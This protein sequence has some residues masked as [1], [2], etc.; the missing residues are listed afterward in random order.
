MHRLLPLLLLLGAAPAP[1]TRW[2]VIL[3]GNGDRIGHAEQT[4]IMTAQGR[5]TRA[6]QEIWLRQD[7]APLRK[8][9]ETSSTRYDPAGRLVSAEGESRS[10]NSAPVRFTLR[11]GPAGADIARTSAGHVE[12]R[13]IPLPA[14]IR[15]DSGTGLLPGWK[16]GVTPRLEFD[17]LNFD[18]GEIEHVVIDAVPGAPGQALRRRYEKGQLR[19][20]ARLTL[21]P[22]GGIDALVQPMFGTA[23]TIRPAPRDEALAPLIAYRPLSSAMVKAPFRIPAAAMQGH[24]RYRFGFR[25]GIA[26]DPPATP[27]QRVTRTGD[28]AT[29]DICLGCGSDLASDPATLADALRPTR[30]LQSDD[31]RI[32]AEVA[33]IARMKVS[34]TRKMELLTQRAMAV[35]TTADFAGHH[36]ALET[37]QSR[38]GDCTEAAAL[39][40]AYGRAAGIPTRVANGL[41]YSREAYHG[42][43]NVFMPHSWVLA[44]VDGHWRSFDSAL[45]AFDA[46]HI[47]LTLGDGDARAV[48]AASQLASLVAWQE[49]AEIRTRPGG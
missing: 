45:G 32:R 4:S 16:P 7:G 34:D 21:D 36:S 49:M 11:I 35:I 8:I 43:S 41:A 47:A 25:D 29:L 12:Q 27:E 1:E 5:E 14:G 33:S 48:A 24:I 15:F 10:G 26:F 42:V 13:T 20:V 6:S 46:T 3:A 30:W 31:R 9:V 19:A 39:L 38:R 17:N 28:G 23:I 2:F 18:A 44:Y 22:A 40:A 37:L